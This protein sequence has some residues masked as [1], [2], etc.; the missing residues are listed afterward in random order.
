MGMDFKAFMESL[1]DYQ[2]YIYDNYQA[3][4]PR[5]LQISLHAAGL[6]FVEKNEGKPKVRDKGFPGLIT[7]IT[8]RTYLKYLLDVRQTKYNEE[9][10]MTLYTAPA[11]TALRH[12]AYIE[13]YEPEDYAAWNSILHSMYSGY[14]SP[15]FENWLN[16]RD[17]NE[18]ILLSLGTGIRRSDPLRG[19]NADFYTHLFDWALLFGLQLAR[20][21]PMSQTIDIRFDSNELR[22]Y[23]KLQQYHENYVDMPNFGSKP[24]PH[25]IMPSNFIPDGAFAL[26]CAVRAA[27]HKEGWID[28]KNTWEWMEGY[29]YPN[30]KAANVA[31]DSELTI[32]FEEHLTK[33]WYRL[34]FQ[35]D[36]E[37]GRTLRGLSKRP[38][39]YWRFPIMPLI[40]DDQTDD[41]RKLNWILS[42]M[43]YGSQMP[44]NGYRVQP[45]FKL[46]KGV[47]GK[48]RIWVDTRGEARFVETDDKGAVKLDKDGKPIISEKVVP[49]SQAQSVDEELPG[50]AIREKPKSMEKTLEV[51]I[52]EPSKTVV[53]DSTE[54]EAK[55]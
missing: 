42:L 24:D 9:R 3:N 51:S 29:E 21:V 52:T 19:L 22:G 15:S 10:I 7:K 26:P 45:F 12:F 32:P 23:E 49:S 38:L 43:C 55:E 17:I 35:S 34:T 48:V 14:G 11:S 39:M 47:R 44:K 33:T 20:A 41:D 13:G 8:E 50:S 37:W 31:G 25:L 4:P 5:G 54:E 36:A 18:S 16:A 28:Y 27:R 1:D 40:W 46:L 30:M 6:S 53:E 2:Q